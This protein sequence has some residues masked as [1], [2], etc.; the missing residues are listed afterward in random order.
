MEK[1]RFSDRID[2]RIGNSSGISNSFEQQGG[3]VRHPGSI[4]FADIAAA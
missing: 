1:R 3:N 2:A 4:A